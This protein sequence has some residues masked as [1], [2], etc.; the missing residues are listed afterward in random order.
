M[1]LGNPQSS[2]TDTLKNAFVR[3]FQHAAPERRQW[4]VDVAVNTPGLDASDWQ[5]KYSRA[6]DVFSG[7]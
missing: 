7:Q 2:T 4:K 5:G 1:K 6:S 3:V